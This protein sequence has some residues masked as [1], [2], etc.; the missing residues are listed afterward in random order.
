MVV[1]EVI[2]SNGQFQKKII[3]CDQLHYRSLWQ[4]QGV[5]L[6]H[7]SGLTKEFLTCYP[8]LQVIAKE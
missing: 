5:V 4:D 6:L 1:E 7:F 8:S 3:N 2:Y